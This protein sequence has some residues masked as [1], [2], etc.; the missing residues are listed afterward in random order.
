VRSWKA[1]TDLRKEHI[2]I[3]NLSKLCLG[4]GKHYVPVQGVELGG[5]KSKENARTNI[6][7]VNFKRWVAVQQDKDS[8]QAGCSARER[9]TGIKSMFWNDQFKVLT[10]DGSS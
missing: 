6:L 2:T 1:K 10:S 7:K 4:R 5:G 8:K 9:L 3:C